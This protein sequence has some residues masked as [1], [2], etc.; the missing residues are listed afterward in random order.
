M[1]F[2]FGDFFQFWFQFGD[3][4]LGVRVCV[5]STHLHS[6]P[7]ST[8]MH[9]QMRTHGTRTLSLEHC[10]GRHRQPRTRCPGAWCCPSTGTLYGKANRT[11]YSRLPMCACACAGGGEG[12]A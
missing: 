1:G 9:M 5:M 8:R 4:C 11:A 6:V 7:L 10:P 3:G 12:E 2:D